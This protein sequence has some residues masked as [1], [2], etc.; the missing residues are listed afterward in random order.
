MSPD[1]ARR[2]ADLYRRSWPEDDEGR[3]YCWWCNAKSPLSC[4]RP[5]AEGGPCGWIG[6]CEPPGSGKEVERCG[7]CGSE[8]L[9]VRAEEAEG[10]PEHRDGCEVEKILRELDA[11]ALL[12][13]RSTRDLHY[14]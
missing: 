2:A 4:A 7:G 13:S 12:S 10:G 3:T 14:D 11:S 8:F 5:A 1:L 9:E 6:S